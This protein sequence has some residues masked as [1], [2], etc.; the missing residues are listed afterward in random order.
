MAQEILRLFQKNEIN[1]IKEKKII[2]MAGHEEGL[3]FFGKDLEGATE[4]L[5]HFLN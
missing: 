3:I 2:V 4:I 1:N 5:L